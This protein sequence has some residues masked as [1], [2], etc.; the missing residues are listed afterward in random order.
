MTTLTFHATLRKS[1]VVLAF[2]LTGLFTWSAWAGTPQ[3]SEWLI[4]ASQLVSKRMFRR[5]SRTLLI[6]GLGFLAAVE[7]A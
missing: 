7:H 6:A 4:V 1:M 2:M 3:K 5:H